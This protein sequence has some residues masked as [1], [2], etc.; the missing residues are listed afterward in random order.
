M[1]YDEEFNINKSAKI[2]GFYSIYTL[3]IF[4][5]IKIS[6]LQTYKLLQAL[7]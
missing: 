2:K 7:K 1:I 4:I 5:M 3:I 6:Y